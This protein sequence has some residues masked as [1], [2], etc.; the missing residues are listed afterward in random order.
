MITPGHREINREDSSGCCASDGCSDDKITKD[1][2]KPDCCRGKE[3]PCCDTSCL[4][5]LALRECVMTA[6]V[7]SG[8]NAQTMCE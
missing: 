3:S 6:A 1:T 5:R 7:P 4:D 2:N 8:S